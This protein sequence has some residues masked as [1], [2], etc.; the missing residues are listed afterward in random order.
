MI[1]TGAGVQTRAARS[2]IGR[3]GI[4]ACLNL[5]MSLNA[6]RLIETANHRAGFANE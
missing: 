1:G 5:V 4:S 2:V 6:T 3:T